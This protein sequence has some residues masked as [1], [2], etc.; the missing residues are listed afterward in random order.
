VYSEPNVGTS[1]KLYFP[2]VQEVVGTSKSHPGL[3]VMPHGTETILLVED[4]E[5]VRALARHVLQMCGYTVLEASHGGEALRLAERHQGPIHLILTD[6]VMPG[7]SGRL[8]AE[9]IG[10]LKPGIKTLFTSGYTDDSVVRHGILE[11]ETHF[12]QKPYTPAAVAQKVR[13][14]LDG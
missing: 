2:E 12:L 7:M 9:R 3:K 6:V 1:F 4:E 8:V 10:A 11:T 13:A 5:G 14:V